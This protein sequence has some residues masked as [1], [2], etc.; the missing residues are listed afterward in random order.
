VLPFPLSISLSNDAI[1]ANPFLLGESFAISCIFY[2]FSISN[3]VYKIYKRGGGG[4][5]VSTLYDH[6]IPSQFVVSWLAT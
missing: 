5:G 4:D 6:V 2:N 3:T 1:G